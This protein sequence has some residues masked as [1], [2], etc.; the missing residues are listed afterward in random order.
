MELLGKNL[1]AKFVGSKPMYPIRVCG[2][3][4]PQESKHTTTPKPSQVLEEIGYP[5][6]GF[7][8]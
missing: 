2:C 3:N 8:P 7:L 1:I 5:L 6:I 4:T